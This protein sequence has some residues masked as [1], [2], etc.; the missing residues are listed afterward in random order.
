MFSVEELLALS[1]FPGLGPV[2]I[3]QLVTRFPTP[4][5]LRTSGRRALVSLE[6]FSE[7][8]ATETQQFLCG[9][10]WNVAMQHA[11][12]QLALLRT[13]GGSILTYWDREY[14]D[15]LRT[16]HDPPVV[17]FLRG[18]LHRS[19]AASV[20]IVGTRTPSAYGIRTAERFALGC[21][22]LGIV[23]VSGLA[24]GIDTA[25][26][27]AV[28]RAAGRTIAVIGSGL[29]VCYPPENA[30]LLERIAE[31][32]AIVSEYAMGSR[33]VAAN[34][35]RRNRIIS[36]LSLGTLVVETDRVGGAMITARLALEQNREVFAVPGTIDAPHAHGCNALI[37]EGRAKLVET[38]SDVLE[39][40]AERLRPIIDDT[41]PFPEANPGRRR[42]SRTAPHPERTFRTPPVM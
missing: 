24:R 14:P 23:V 34:F 35:P 4:S 15:P 37:R 28:L 22:R 11:Q 40:L 12:G 26:H 27:R 18:T 20:A 36:G 31:H 3:R 29:D 17:L 38:L 19:D 2:R 21:A 8:L 41:I 7:R 10:A 32:G 6:G 33:P 16:I 1:S 13:V 5:A 9:R 39:E 25:A 30:R 42:A